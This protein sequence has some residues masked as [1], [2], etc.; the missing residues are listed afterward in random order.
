MTIPNSPY[1]TFDD[2][3]DSPPLKSAYL[4]GYFGSSIEA[5]IL[6]LQAGRP[7]DALDTLMRA[8]ELKDYAERNDNAA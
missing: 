4:A 8:K 6:A 1:P 7:A 3:G 5:A 2:M